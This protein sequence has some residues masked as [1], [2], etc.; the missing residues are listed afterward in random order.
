MSAVAGRSVHTWILFKLSALCPAG[1]SVVPNSCQSMISL[2]LLYAI[3]R[4]R[5]SSPPTKPPDQRWT[6]CMAKHGWELFGAT[7]ILCKNLQLGTWVCFA[8]LKSV[9]SPASTWKQAAKT[10]WESLCIMDDKWSN[11]SCFVAGIG[12]WNRCQGGMQSTR[13]LNKTNHHFITEMDDGHMDTAS[14]LNKQAS[15]PRSKKVHG[16]YS[17]QLDCTVQAGELLS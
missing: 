9:L 12:V 17:S 4:K 5:W 11:T 6:D 8:S 1:L 14:S 2:L 3:K 10:R 15:A 16:G 7:E 13:T